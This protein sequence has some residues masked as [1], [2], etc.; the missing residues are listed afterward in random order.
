MNSVDT[1]KCERTS[2][3]T[4]DFVPEW[5]KKKMIDNINNIESIR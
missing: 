1:L 2:L 3:F 5:Q 4:W